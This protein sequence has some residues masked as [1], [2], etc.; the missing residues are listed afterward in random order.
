MT[1]D[2]SEDDM[3]DLAAQMHAAVN[4]LDVAKVEALLEAGVPP[5]VWGIDVEYDRPLQV[6]ARSKGERALSIA[7]AL[8]VAGAEIDF[9]GD[10]GCTALA[11]SIERDGADDWAVARY[12]IGA[13]A[14]P[15]LADKDCFCP[16]EIANKNGN[17][18][19]I[20]AMLEAGMDANVHGPVGPLIW[21]CAWD[22]PE[23]VRALLA[24]GANPNGV[25]TGIGCRGQTPLQRA[26]ESF[27]ECSIDEE[28]FRDIAIQLIEAG[29]DPAQIDPAPNCLASFLLS[30]KE[31]ADLTGL[32][33][34]IVEPTPLET[35]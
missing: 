28:S 34:V 23:M 13:K 32:L 31:K 33:P 27:G 15:S 30:R 3:D 21:Y 22:E 4:A 17:N 29:A 2:F 8:I 18:A 6:V 7:K 10:Y 12:L 24:H 11:R 19:A 9:Q 25:A 5:D 14:D 16:A 26:A 1:T 20:L 35:L